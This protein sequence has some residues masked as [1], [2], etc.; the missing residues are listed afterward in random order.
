MLAPG[1]TRELSLHATSR[2]APSCAPRRALAACDEEVAVVLG[3]EGAV[4]AS[5]EATTVYH[6]ELGVFAPR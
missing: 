2:R 6:C 5:D 4:A 3:T 1:E